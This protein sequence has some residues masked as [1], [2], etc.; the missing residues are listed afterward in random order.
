[1]NTAI[2]IYNIFI[3]IQSVHIKSN[4][5]NSFELVDE[6]CHVSLHK[7]Y[8]FV[9]RKKDFTSTSNPKI[10][11]QLKYNNKILKEFDGEFGVTYN[12]DCD[13]SQSML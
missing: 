5:E 1:M 8:R 6:T 3:L 7:L 13:I 4:V 2:Y 11:I 12:I 10:N 9:I